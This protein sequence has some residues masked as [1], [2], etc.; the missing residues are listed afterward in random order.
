MIIDKILDAAEG[1]YDARDFYNYAMEHESIF[2]PSDEY[3]ISTALDSGSNDDV[4]REL[5]RYIDNNDYNKNIK[6]FVNKFN[7][8]S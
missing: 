2:D 6:R 7:W 8:I 3:P 4:R 1:S 5:C